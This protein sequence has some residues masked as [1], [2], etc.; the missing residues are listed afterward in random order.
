M[1]KRSPRQGCRFFKLH[2]AG[3]DLLVVASSEMPA[4]NK[5]AFVRK[6]AHRNLGI[7]CD[8][9]I[10]LVSRRPLAI[11]IWNQDGSKA[12]MCA[13]GSRTFLFLA[14]RERWIDRKAKRVT[15][16]ISGKEYEA[17]QASAG[18]YELSLG[19]PQIGP[20]ESLSLMGRSIPFHPVTTGNPHAVV[21]M[22]GKSAWKAPPGF[23][24]RSYGAKMETHRR[25]PRKANVEFVRSIRTK[26]ATAQI[27]VEA[28]ER[29]AGA[30]LSCGSGAVAAAAVVRQRMP[31]I[32]LFKVKMTDFTLRIRFEGAVA[33]ISG[34]CAL[35]AEGDFF[36]VV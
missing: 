15:V 29:G 2:G 13:N 33:F 32:N 22:A 18:N 35:V 23:D 16:R 4:S 3:N 25:F 31:E 14:A 8:Q 10:E 30:T 1:Q 28:W 34:P 24:Y 19:T 36:P 7:G 17:I 21:L 5:A 12:E 11:Q 27:L 20:P 26:G 6:I 9:V